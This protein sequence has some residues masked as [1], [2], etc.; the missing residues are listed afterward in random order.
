MKLG[1]IKNV[2]EVNLLFMEVLV[3]SIVET[4]HCLTEME[5]SEAVVEAA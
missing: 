5:D 1:K 4:P 2:C 3:D